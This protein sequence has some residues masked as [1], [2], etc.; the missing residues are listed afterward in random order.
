M[1]RLQ[2][3][4]TVVMLPLLLLLPLQGSPVRILC[5]Q[6]KDQW[7]KEEPAGHRLLGDFHEDT[8]GPGLE[9]RRCV[10]RTGEY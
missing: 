9:V 2:C 10:N 5:H 3:H 6:C 1:S 4:P 7:V 8:M